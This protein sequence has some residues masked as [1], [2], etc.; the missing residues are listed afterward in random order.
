MTAITYKFYVCKYFGKD[1]REVKHKIMRKL[2]SLLK[3]LTV[4]CGSLV[5][6]QDNFACKC[7]KGSILVFH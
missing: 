3:D 5:E 2:F 1:N 4:S 6:S 7:P